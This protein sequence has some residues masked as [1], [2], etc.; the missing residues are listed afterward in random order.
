V[1]DKFLAM[2]AIYKDVK[3]SVEGQGVSINLEFSPF[4]AN[5]YTGKT[6]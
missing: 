6:I 1:E 5:G 2:L 4:S 3:V